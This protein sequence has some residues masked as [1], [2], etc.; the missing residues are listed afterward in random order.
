MQMK[1]DN[2]LVDP[3]PWTTVKIGLIVV[4]DN[5]KKQYSKGIVKAVGPGPVLL[6]SGKHS[7]IEVE[8]G[9]HILYH[10]GG[11]IPLIVKGKEMHVVREREIIAVLE[12]G[13]FGVVNENNQKGES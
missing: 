3:E 9:D 7:P 2:V 11:P 4:P 10:I 5:T 6:F 13:D 12:K 1:A 8:V